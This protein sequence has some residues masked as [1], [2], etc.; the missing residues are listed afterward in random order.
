MST[1]TSNFRYFDGPHIRIPENNNYEAT[2]YV[3]DEINQCSILSQTFPIESIDSP[4]IDFDGFLVDAK[5]Y[6]LYKHVIIPDDE[7]VTHGPIMIFGDIH[8][9]YDVL[10]GFLQKNNVIDESYTWIWGN[11]QLVFTGDVFDRGSQVTECVWLIHRL[12]QEAEKAGGN[13]H[14]LLGNHEIMAF[15]NDTRYLNEKYHFICRSFGIKYNSLFSLKTYLGNWLRTRN[16]IIKINDILISHGGVS[17]EMLLLNTDIH[18]INDTVRKYLFNQPTTKKP[19]TVFIFGSYGPFWY[20][21][22]VSE[23]LAYNKMTEKDIQNVLSHFNAATIVVGHT[24]IDR[25]T[26]LFSGKVFATDIPYYIPGFHLESLLISDN[27]YYRCLHTGNQ[28]EILD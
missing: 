17:K 4:V 10:T 25:I 20:R 16:T 27:K 21:G 8:G 13:V 6:K 7:Y 22:Y 2:Y 14:L 5:K 18:D 1:I 9:G 12:S 24:N 28:E 23:W 19:L 15:E 26:P 3:L 11:G